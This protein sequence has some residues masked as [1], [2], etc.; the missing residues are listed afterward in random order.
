MAADETI[1][2]VLLAAG[3][4]R[5]MG[6]FKPLLPFGSRSVV[7]TCVANL[8]EAG[9]CEVV[10][11]VGHRGEEVR[12]ALAGETRVRFAV[13]EVEGSEMG[14]SVA[15]G[16]EAVNAEAKAVLVALVDYPAVPT[17]AIESLIEARARTGARLVAPEWQ[18]RGGHPVLVDLTLREE[19]LSVVHE[20]GL[21]ALFDARRAEVLRVPSD[22]PFVT[23][24]MDTWDDYVALHTEAF[25]VPPEK[26]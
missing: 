8:L 18:G 25:G 11:V 21:R 17:S 12:A 14:V 9:A 19:L 16:V 3:R 24:D 23:R 22:S 7:E 26:G 4:S 1:S 13:N 15:R 10:V 5:R 20:K 6:A 2:A